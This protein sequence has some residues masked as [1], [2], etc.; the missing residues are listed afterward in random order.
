MDSVR[1][2][3]LG[4][5]LQFLSAASDTSVNPT[6]QHQHHLHSDD[7]GDWLTLSYMDDEN[8]LVLMSSDAD[9]GDAI[10]MAQMAKQNRVRLFVHDTAAPLG[11]SDSIIAQMNNRGSERLEN[12]TDDD[13]QMTM[14]H[15]SRKNMH[16]KRQQDRLGGAT[17]Q[18]QDLIL[19]AAITF[20]GVVIIGVFA[21]S[22]IGRSQG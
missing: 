21:Y 1:Q 16:G 7:T 20:L 6:S 19:P 3:V 12:L 5:H 13:E 9:V 14:E 22:R 11:T 17:S 18:R 2:K 4:E 15:T 8:D 10:R